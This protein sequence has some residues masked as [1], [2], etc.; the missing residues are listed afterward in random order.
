MPSASRCRKRRLPRAHNTRIA[1][2]TLPGVSCRVDENSQ[3]IYVTAAFGALKPNE[4]GPPESV[5]SS[6]PVRSSIGAVINYNLAGTYAE[7]R[8]FGDAFFD[9]RLFSPWAVAESSFTASNVRGLQAAPVI[10][11]DSA[12]TASYTATLTQYQLGDLISSGLDWSRPVRMGGFQISTNFGIRP[13]LTTFPV[14]TIAG[15]VAVPSS[16]DVLVNGVQELSQPTPAGPF[17]IRQLPVVTGAGDVAVVVRNAAG[18]QTIQTLQFYGSRQLVAPGLNDFSAE[19][20]VVRLNYGMRSNDYRAPAGSASL[21]RGLTKWLTLQGHVEASAGGGSY[22]G[23]KIAAG[24]MA[25][26]GV[27]L[28]LGFGI[29]SG[30]I[31]VSRFGRHSGGLAA[32]GVERVAPHVSVSVS[33]QAT[34][35]AFRD[36]AALYGDT[37]P[38]LQA[39]AVLGLSWSNTGLVWHSLHRTAPLR[40]ACPGKSA[41][42]R[43]RADGNA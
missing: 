4:L 15:E 34:A 35:G 16:I 38:S 36:I 43:R 3:T 22:E 1:L 8:L 33:V 28:G 29:I 2:T 17:E 12:V 27:V 14:P 37:V 11:L 18:Q 23:L 10:R 5:A 30:D 24:G 26:G 19:L 31:A 6:L 41:E 7:H 39:R 9:G 13:D 21:R 32:V 25:G 20:G 40:I 42:S